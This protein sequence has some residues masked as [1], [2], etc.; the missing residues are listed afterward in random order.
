M[1]DDTAAPKLRV[2]DVE[3]MLTTKPPPVPYRAKPLLVNGCVTMLAG[4]EGQGKS[5]FALALTAAIGDG[6]TVA[7]IDCE[8]G[9]TLIVD[10]ENGEMEAWRRVHGLGIRP[11]TLVYVEA[12]GF[13][14]RQDFA[15]L[16]TLVE[17]REP[18][19]IVLD[20]L[21]S[22]APGLDENDSMQTEAA[23]RPVVRLAQSSGRAVLILHHAGKTGVDYRGSTAIGAAVELGFTLS[24]HEDDPENQ[25]RRRLTCWKCRPAPEPPTRWIELGVDASGGIVLDEAEPFIIERDAPVRDEVEVVLREYIEG[26]PVVPTLRGEDNRTTPPEFPITMQDQRLSLAEDNGTT[27][28]PW[29]GSHLA[30]VLG[31]DKSD[32][33]VRKALDRLAERGVIHRGEDGRWYPGTNH[34]KPYLPGEHS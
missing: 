1:G 7:G 4:R 24:R 22:L 27:A 32:K 33:T 34:S 30:R 31:R 25:T 20:S 10:A 3:T 17:A 28:P 2:L 26:C 8:R 9:T 15:R 12:D 16:Q 21:R 14:L 18:N 13:D 29:T 11:G 6:T 19:V 23:L 5:M